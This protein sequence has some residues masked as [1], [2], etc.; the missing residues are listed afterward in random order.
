MRAG[1]H[2]VRT[3]PRC[4]DHRGRAPH[5][6]YIDSF[7]SFRDWFLQYLHAEADGLFPDVPAKTGALYWSKRINLHLVLAKSAEQEPE[8]P[9]NTDP[10]WNW[11]YDVQLAASRIESF[12]VYL[13]KHER[14]A[15][16]YYMGP[17]IMVR[18]LRLNTGHLA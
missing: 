10:D 9:L 4:I 12:H 13:L 14:R 5:R 2:K 15:K 17:L 11:R 8:V 3:D 7:G 1:L 16:Y 6:V 18:P